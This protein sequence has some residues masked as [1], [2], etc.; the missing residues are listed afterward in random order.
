MIAI[1]RNNHCLFSESYET[2]ILW[3]N[4]EYFSLMLEHLVLTEHPAIFVASPAFK[5][6]Y[7]EKKKKTPWP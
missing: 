5:A 1:F 3:E 7:S 6:I 4:A 2:N